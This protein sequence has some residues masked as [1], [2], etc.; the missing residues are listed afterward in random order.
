MTTRRQFLRGAVSVAVAASIPGGDGVALYSAKHPIPA[1]LPMVGDADTGIFSPNADSISF[2]PI[3]HEMSERMV[4]ALCK[5]LMETKEIVGA[6]VFNRAFPKGD[7]LRSPL[8]D[9]LF[10]DDSEVHRS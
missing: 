7:L 2:H 6:N 1:L 9:D 10:A 4:E 5:S 8:T 3:P